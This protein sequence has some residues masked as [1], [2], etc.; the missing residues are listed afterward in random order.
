[1]KFES[2]NGNNVSRVSRKNAVSLAK[3]KNEADI[4]FGNFPESC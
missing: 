2:S 3:R 4:L 1:M